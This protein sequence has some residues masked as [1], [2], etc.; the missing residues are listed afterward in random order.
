MTTI[1]N[2]L[3]F[4][5]YNPTRELIYAAALLVGPFLIDKLSLKPTNV[6]SQIDRI[7]E[8]IFG[9]K[10][11]FFAF[12]QTNA[13]TKHTWIFLKNFPTCLA[14]SSLCLLIICSNPETVVDPY[15][16]HSAKYAL[17]TLFSLITLAPDDDAK[18]KRDPRPENFPYPLNRYNSN[19]LSFQGFKDSGPLF[20]PKGSKSPP[21]SPVGQPIKQLC[22]KINR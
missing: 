21:I 14:L 11:Q 17:A 22:L 20:G 7:R 13:L 19:P 1:T 2:M 18:V 10:T 16:F 3:G 6:V 5:S 15:M 8:N 12:T 4:T 9:V